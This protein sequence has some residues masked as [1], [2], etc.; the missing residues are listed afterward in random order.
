MTFWDWFGVVVVAVVAVFVLG[1]LVFEL[2][3][4]AWFRLTFVWDEPQGPRRRALPPAEQPAL[5]ASTTLRATAVDLRTLE[6]DR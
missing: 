3:A 6:L 1:R 2:V 5:P 4:D